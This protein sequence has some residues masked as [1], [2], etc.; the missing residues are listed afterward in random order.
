M[1]E[2]DAHKSK[3]VLLTLVTF[4]YPERCSISKQ[5]L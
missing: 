5:R 2:Q 4:H 1:D 3:R